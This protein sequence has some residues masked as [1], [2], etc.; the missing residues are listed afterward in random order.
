MVN[1]TMGRWRATCGHLVRAHAHRF[2]AVVVRPDP[3]ADPAPS[4]CWTCLARDMI[5]LCG[6]ACVPH[7]RNPGVA[8]SAEMT[9]PAQENER[10]GCGS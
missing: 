8:A 4:K 1:K 3:N 10:E 6:G 2:P 9:Q 7:P 5:L